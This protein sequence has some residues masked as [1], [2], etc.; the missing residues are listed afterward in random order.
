MSQGFA[1]GKYVILDTEQLPK[2]A[3]GE[4][5]VAKNTAF[6]QNTAVYEFLPN[7]FRS[8][9]SLGGTTSISD[10]MFQVSSSASVGSYGTIQSFRS[11]NYN[12]GQGGLARFTALFENNVADSWSGVGLVTITDELSFGYSGTVFGIWHRR[13]GV[14]E[15]RT[16]T[17][18]VPSSGAT[19][20]TLTLNSTAYTIPLTA[21]S[22]ALNA[23]EIATWLNA[24]QSVWVADQIDGAVIISAESDGAKSGTYSYSH[25]TST[26][27]ITQNKAGVTKTSDHIP[28]ASWNGEDVTAW[29]S[30]LDPAKGNVYQIAYQYLGFGDIRFY[31]EN[32]A[33]G[34][35]AL[36][37]TI[38]WANDNTRTSVGNPS[39][40][41]GMYAVSTGTTTP[42]IVKSASVALFVQGDVFKT[43]NPRSV[44]NTQ[45]IS[46]TLKNVV[47][48]RNRRTYNSV[49][50]QVEIEPVSLSIASESSK[51]VKVQLI[52]NPTFSG[53]TNYNTT[54]NNLV[55]DFDISGNTVSN[56]TVLAT[57]YLAP[58]STKE[59]DLV[60]FS[61]RIPPSLQLSI[62]AI[63]TGGGAASNVSAALTYYE[64]I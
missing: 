33:T 22:A 30:P 43:R 60:P 49:Y 63:V 56:G 10:K 7:N 29:D 18:T 34:D 12:S 64:D 14:A 16:I 28:V 24:N 53:A 38:K 5:S 26:A 21:G 44:D 54:G 45:S 57:F 41:F 52:T 47:A 35:F 2:T 15:V 46:G 36:V 11:L 3:F 4:M 40:R 58:N 19:N 62:C 23:Y 1:S 20:L 17:I 37:H 50:N 51:N 48:I 25:A 8:Y 32:N 55:T 59:I 6:V 42:V 27:T 13:H 61:I 31:V 39:M 9:T